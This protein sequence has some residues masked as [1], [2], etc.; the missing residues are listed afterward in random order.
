[1]LYLGGAYIPTNI[2]T[3]TLSQEG[4]YKP[5]G[6]IAKGG[7]YIP[8]NTVYLAYKPSPSEFQAHI[9]RGAHFQAELALN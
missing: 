8:V 7:A 5:G 9:G 3:V 4:A 1:M 2:G 6:L